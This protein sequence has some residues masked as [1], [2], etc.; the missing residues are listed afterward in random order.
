ML[1]N[2]V[3]V[4][5]E[6]DEP[7]TPL[8]RDKVIR[9]GLWRRTA[10]VLIVNPETGQIL[11]Q[12]RSD[13]KDERPG[14]WISMFG[15]KSDPEE[16]PVQTATREVK[17]EADITLSP[18]Q[19]NFFIKVRSVKH[20]QFEYLFWAKWQGDISKL[21]YDKNEVS[22]IGWYDIDIVLENLTKNIKEWY[23]YGE[24]ELAT[25]RQAKSEIRF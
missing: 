14:V 23:C 15:G 19:L 13:T 20:H 17:E 22:E 12:K 18:E 6:N 5:N 10:G 4:V 1:E 8:P 7:L 9:E 24:G 3:F 11:C 2:L 25:I 21:H 16:T